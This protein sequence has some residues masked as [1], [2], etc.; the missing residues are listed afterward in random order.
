MLLAEGQVKSVSECASLET[1]CVIFWLNGFNGREFVIPE[2]IY[3]SG[4]VIFTIFSRN[5]YIQR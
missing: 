1:P 4:F 5:V 2:V 3:L